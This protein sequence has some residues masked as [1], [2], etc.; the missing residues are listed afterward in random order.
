[1][2]DETTTTAETTEETTPTA[3][4]TE[5]K[6]T[7]ELQKKMDA[8]AANVRKEATATATA[9]A[10]KALMEE[11]GLNPDDPKAVDTV[12]ARLTA[13]QQAEDAKKSAET[14]A[15]EKIAQLEKERDE[16][17]AART[18]LELKSRLKDRDDEVKTALSAARCTNPV[19][20]LGLLGVFQTAELAAT[21]KE[22]GTLDKT[23]LTALVE[24]AKKEHKEYFVG[25]GPGIPPTAPGGRAS[26]GMDE[27]AARAANLRAARRD[28]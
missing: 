6:I 26:G 8:V 15:L 23:K 10:R 28:I 7:P 20:V 2:P 3:Q 12:K 1:M 19:K 17:K 18:A 22:D 9:A 16:A 4:P 24:A 5:P 14:L 13:A 11:L 27:N 25:G 21:L